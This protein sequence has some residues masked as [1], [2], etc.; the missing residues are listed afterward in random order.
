MS[1]IVPETSTTLLRE[2]SS[3]VENARWPEF[4]SRYR[5]MMVAYL[6]ARFP[7]V[8]A[9]DIVQETLIAL[10]KALPPSR[11]DWTFQELFDRN[12]SP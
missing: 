6:N 7:Y 5:P 4:V 12:P 1:T 10:S 3:D 9:D 11:R 8:D 2:I